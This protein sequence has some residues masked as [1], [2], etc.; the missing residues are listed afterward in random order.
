[1]ARREPEPFE[2]ELPPAPLL[3]LEMARREPEAL[4]TS[5]PTEEILPHNPAEGHSRATASAACCF[6]PPAAATAGAAH[7]L[8]QQLRPDDTGESC[9]PH[10]RDA[11]LAFKQG[12][13]FDYDDFLASWRRGQE[14]EEDCCRWRGVTCN[15]RTGHVA[16]LDLGGSF[17]D[18]QISPSLLSLEQLE[19][20]DLSW[21]LFSGSIPSFLG[22]F[23]NLR[24]L[25]LSS[26]DFTGEV[27]HQLGNLSNLRQLDLGSQP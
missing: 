23:K 14:E 5:T 4:R 15:N 26:N 21:T 1:M 7:A 11:L 2:P 8:E 25:N 22:G 6:S 19:Y 24:Y 3:P 12:I 16:K 9:L 17:L 13:N 10:E 20:L 18:D 27:P